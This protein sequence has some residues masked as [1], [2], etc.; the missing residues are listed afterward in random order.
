MI[1]KFQVLVSYF[2]TPLCTTPFSGVLT[3]TGRTST[4]EGFF[5]EILNSF[6]VATIFAKNL[7]VWV[8][9]RLLA[10]RFKI[11]SSLLLPVCKL[12]SCWESKRNECLY[13]SGRPKGSFKK[14][15]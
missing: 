10:K 1:K 2:T 3:E 11:L 8:E 5:A 4:M 15:L 12:R 7:L 14:A 6:K 9:N 13:R